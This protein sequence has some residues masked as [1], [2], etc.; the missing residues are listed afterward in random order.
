M[1]LTIR[2]TS[3]TLIRC[4]FGAHVSSKLDSELDLIGSWAQTLTPPLKHSN[5]A[6]FEMRKRKKMFLKLLLLEPNLFGI[7]EA[8]TLWP[9]KDPHDAITISTSMHA[10]C[11]MNNIQI[12]SSNRDTMWKVCLLGLTFIPKVLFSSKEIKLV[13]YFKK[14]IQILL[15]FVS[16]QNRS[17]TVIP[18][19]SVKYSSEWCFV[20]NFWNGPQNAEHP[21]LCPTKQGPGHLNLIR[22]MHH[23]HLSS[24]LK[25]WYGCCLLLQSY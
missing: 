12:D 5:Q 6:I 17:M 11:A 8:S 22:N 23:N 25:S 24:V 4:V 15:T 19:H 20:K 7:R 1:F 18:I 10:P 2:Y 14:L 13:F 3:L 21:T 9:M 16:T